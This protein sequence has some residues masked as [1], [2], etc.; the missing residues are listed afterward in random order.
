MLRRLNNKYSTID[1]SRRIDTSIHMSSPRFSTKRDPKS[2]SRGVLLYSSREE[3]FARQLSI[4]RLAYD[5]PGL[6]THLSLRYIAV[7][8]IE[9]RAPLRKGNICHVLPDYTLPRVIT[10]HARKK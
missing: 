5:Y 7:T 10:N 2:N 1:T 6:G 4:L 9:F 3:T 8:P